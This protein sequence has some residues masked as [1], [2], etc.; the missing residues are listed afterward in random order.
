MKNNRYYCYLNAFLQCLAP[1]SELRNHFLTQEYAKY[2]EVKTKRDDFSFS[3]GMF[4]FYKYM[5][6]M[7]A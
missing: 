1:I 7:E 5:F 4:L 2:K 3:N 6:K